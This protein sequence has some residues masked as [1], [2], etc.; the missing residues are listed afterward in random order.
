LPRPWRIAP[1]PTPDVDV[2][3]LLHVALG[4]SEYHEPVAELD[5][6]TR[7]AHR[8]LLSLQEE[9]EAVDWYHQRLQCCA[10]PEL[11]RIL[12]HNQNEEME[13]AAMLLEWVRRRMPGWDERLRPM[14]FT[15]R[16]L[17][18]EPSKDATA[19]VADPG[20]RGLGIGSL[21]GEP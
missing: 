14:L 15:T 3:R 8:A 4:M 9:I 10:D 6:E 2:A 1:A 11:A 21:K 12:E 18:P 17:G 20:G 19:A 7:D 5:G 16:E 13:H